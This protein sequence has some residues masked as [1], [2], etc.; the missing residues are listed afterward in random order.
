MLRAIEDKPEWQQN[1]ARITDC[2]CEVAVG[3]GIRKLFQSRARFFVKRLAGCCDAGGIPQ[4][5]RNDTSG[6]YQVTATGPVGSTPASFNLTNTS[7][8][9]ATL[10]VVSGGNQTTDATTQF[11][12]PLVISVVD[13]FGNPVPNSP[14]TLTLP[15]TGATATTPVTLVTGSDGTLTVPLTAGATPG[16]FTATVAVGGTATPVTTQYTVLAIPTVTTLTVSPAKPSA[17]DPVTFTATVTSDHGTPTGVVRFVMRGETVSAPVLAGGKA[18]YKIASPLEG[19]LEITAF[20]DAQGSFEGSNSAPAS[21]T[22]GPDQGNLNGAS[23]A[24]GCS[25]APGAAGALAWLPLAFV[26]LWLSVRARRMGQKGAWGAALFF[27]LSAPLAARAQAQ[28][29]SA[30]ANI[31]FFHNAPAGSDWFS[32]DSLDLRG[33]LRPSFRALLDYAHDPL[34]IYNGAGHWRAVPVRQQLFLDLGASLVFLDRFRVSANLPISFH[35][36]GDRTSLEGGYRVDP[37]RKTY[38]ADMSVSAD[39]MLLGSYGDAATLAIGAQVTFPTGSEAAFTGDAHVTAAPHLLF[40]GRAGIFAYAAQLAY[41]FRGGQVG[42]VNFNDELRYGG[43]AGI[44][45][46]DKKM[47]VGPEAY[48]IADFGKSVGERRPVGV[49]VD[50]GAHY[51]YDNQWRFGLGVG[52]DAVR[53]PGVPNVRGL[54]S[55]EWIMPLPKER[56]RPVQREVAVVVLD[57]DHDGVPDDQDLCPDVPQGEHPD[58]DRLGCPI[59]DAD[60]DGVPDTVDLCP[61]VVAGPHPDANKRGCPDSDRD[62]DGVFDSQDVCPDEPSGRF[63]DAER[64]GCPLPDRDHDQVPDSVDACPDQPGAPHRNP[65]RNGCPGLIKVQNNHIVILKP[66]QFATGKATILPASD[67]VLRGVA[68]ALEASPDLK[69]ISIEGHTDTK[70][71]PEVNLVLSDK[72]SHAV[73]DWLVKHGIAAERLEAHGFGQTVPLMTNSTAAG[74]QANRR[75]EFRIVE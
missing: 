57:R 40:A 49:E 60:G 52:T 46:L 5:R 15:S 48:G 6:T 31:D 23:G 41:A 39:A 13:A 30:G 45:L 38:L 11:P 63:P 70:G 19:T 9:P 59:V 12:A 55:A 65:K 67:E 22:V 17:Y 69:H 64:L 68:E 44:L 61:T 26:A 18:S 35:E 4:F 50:L 74:R 20:Y 47:L 10:M 73:L 32:Q 34:V 53:S 14:V 25:A 66:I 37:A 7:G 75:V 72:R 36:F 62:G 24:A 2:R 51:T 43:S 8:P 33:N 42:N 56:P 27:L 21:V 58:L 3:I 16:T 28:P 29:H 54:L 71:K 1:I